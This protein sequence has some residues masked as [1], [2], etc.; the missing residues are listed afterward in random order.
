MDLPYS[1]HD[2]TVRGLKYADGAITLDLE[3]GTDDDSVL[4]NTS[5]VF[6]QVENL[7]I[8]DAPG[9]E[10]VMVSEDGELL[11]LEMSAPGGYVLIEWNWY[12]RPRRQ[13]ELVKYTFSFT[14]VEETRGPDTIRPAS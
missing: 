14:S 11:G 6:R 4:A 9:S 5:I 2:A 1:H 7:L 8:N 12:G 3:C 10:L 13:S